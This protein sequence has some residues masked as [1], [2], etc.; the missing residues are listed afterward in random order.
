MDERGQE[1]EKRI[2]QKIEAV[3]DGAE[4]DEGFPSKELTYWAAGVGPG[5][6]EDSY[7]SEGHQY[8]RMI[9]EVRNDIC[10]VMRGMADSEVPNRI[11]RDD[12]RYNWENYW[13]IDTVTKLTS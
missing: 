2:V 7:D 10:A 13:R 11:Y 8:Y 12:P 9:Q 5:T 3:G 6:P 1:R 4:Q